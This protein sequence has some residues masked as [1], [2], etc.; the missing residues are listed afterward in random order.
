MIQNT[1]FLEARD[2]V[3]EDIQVVF[4]FVERGF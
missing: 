3:K 2:N 4:D 1:I